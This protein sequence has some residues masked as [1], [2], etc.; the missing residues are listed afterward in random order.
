MQMIRK[1]LLSFLF[2]LAFSAT[3]QVQQARGK[4]TIPY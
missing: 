4:A 3:A 1:I 2:C